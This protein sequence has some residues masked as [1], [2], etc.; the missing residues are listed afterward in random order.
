MKIEPRELKAM[1][2]IFF[3]LIEITKG[4]AKRNDKRLV[5]TKDAVIVKDKKSKI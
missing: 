4:V 5:F 2:E 1:N 3:N